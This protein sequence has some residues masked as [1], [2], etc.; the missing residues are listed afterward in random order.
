MKK[1]TQ[2]WRQQKSGSFPRN[3]AKEEAH[4]PP[5]GSATMTKRLGRLPVT[6]T[7]RKVVAMVTNTG[8]GDHLQ[9]GCGSSMVNTTNNT[10]FTLDLDEDL[11]SAVELMEQDLKSGKSPRRHLP[12]SKSPL[13][14]STP[15]TS[16]KR[17]NGNWS[18]KK[19]TSGNVSAGL[20]GSRDRPVQVGITL[21]GKRRREARQAGNKSVKKKNL[22]SFSNNNKSLT[23]SNSP[24]DKKKCSGLENNDSVKKV[25]KSVMPLHISVDKSPHKSSSSGIHF[26][27]IKSGGSESVKRFTDLQQKN[28]TKGKE[29]LF[30]DTSQVNERKSE[31]RSKQDAPENS[32]S[33]IPGIFSLMKNNNRIDTNSVDKNLFS[34]KSSYETGEGDHEDKGKTKTLTKVSTEDSK[35]STVPCQMN[36][37]SSEKTSKEGEIDKLST[38]VGVSGES[39]DSSRL[40]LSSWGLPEPVLKQYNSMGITQMFE[41]QAECLCIGNVLGGGN[42]VYAAP[43]SAGKTM[44]AELLILKRV[45]ETRKKALFILPFVSVTREKMFSLQQLYQDA[46]IRVSGFMGGY[47]PPGGFN[48]VDV[49]VCTIEK[50]NSLINRLIEEKTTDQLGIIVVDELHMVGDSHRGYLLELLLTKIAY[51]ANKG[52]PKAGEKSS[53]DYNPVQIVG[54]SATLPNLDLLARWLHADVFRTDFRPVPLTECLKLGAVLFNSE[55]RKIGDINMCH[56]CKGDEDHIIPLCLETVLAGHAVLIFC[57][58]KNWCEKLCETIAREFYM[59]MKNPPTAATDKGQGFQKAS[60]LFR[61]PLNATALRDVYLQL[62]RTPVGVDSTLGKTVPYGVAFH[63]AGLTFDERDI[64][65]GAFRNGSLKVLVATSTLSSG[66]NLPARRVIIRSVMFHGKVIEA[67]TYKQMAGRAGRK[68]VD[69]AGEC[70]LVC[71]QNEKTKAINLMKSELP[72]VK[73]CLIRED[74]EG[75]SSCM[76]RAILEIVVSGVAVAPVDVAAYASC[77]MLAASMSTEHSQTGELIEA[78]ITFLQEN[79]FVTLKSETD[80][81]G[82][83]TE[84]FYPTQLGAAV[85]ASA[86]SPDEGL[87]VF[88]EL[89]RAR[90]CFVLE[91]ELHVIYL[92]TPIYSHEIS[93]SIDWYQFYC[94]WEKLSPSAL[95][96]A[97][98]VGVQESFI[99]RA[100]RGRILMKTDGQLRSLGIHRRFYTSLVLLDLV[101]EV[102]LPEV[103]RR[104]SCNKGQLQSLQ[105]SAATFAGMVTVFCGRLGWYN[106]ELI[107]SQFQNRLTFG[108]Q[109]ELCDLVRVS[110][111]NGQR[112]RTLYNGGYQTIASLANADSSDVENLLK[113]SAP[114]QSTK[115][116]DGESEWELAERRK[117]HCIWL[118][119]K[120]GVTELEAAQAIISEA[121]SIIE[122]ELGGLGIQWRSSETQKEQTSPVSAEQDGITDKRN[123]SGNISRTRRSSRSSKK[124]PSNKTVS[125]LNITNTCN[126]DRSFVGEVLSPPPAMRKCSQPTAQSPLAANRVEINI[127]NSKNPVV[128][129]QMECMLQL[130]KPSIKTCNLQVPDSE[131]KKSSTE[132]CLFNDVSPTVSFNKM[133]AKKH[134]RTVKKD[135]PQTSENK[136]RNDFSADARRLDNSVLKDFQIT[137]CDSVHQVTKS[138]D[139][140]QIKKCDGVHNTVERVE[141]NETENV[142]GDVKVDGHSNAMF[143]P[144]DDDD[145]PRI[146]LEPVVNI[147][148]TSDLMNDNLT[149][150]MFSQSFSAET[151]LSL[152]QKAQVVKPH[153][154]S[155]KDDGGESDQMQDDEFTDSFLFNTQIS[156]EIADVVK[157]NPMCPVRV[158][159]KNGDDQC[160]TEKKETSPNLFT[161]QSENLLQG[162]D[163]VRLDMDRKAEVKLS[164]NKKCVFK[165]MLAEDC[166]CSLQKDDDCSVLV[167]ASNY[168][169]VNY[170]SSDFMDSTFQDDAN[171]SYTELRIPNADVKNKPESFNRA[172]DR[173]V[174][175]TVVIN[176][177]TE[178]KTAVACIYPGTGFNENISM[179]D[180]FSCSLADAAMENVNALTID[181]ANN[182][183][184]TYTPIAAVGTDDSWT[185]SMMEKVLD[186]QFE[187]S[188]PEEETRKLS[189]NDRKLGD[190]DNNDFLSVITKHTEAT[191]E[192]TKVDQQNMESGST[193]MCSNSIQSSHFNKKSDSQ[194]LCFNKKAME[195][196][197]SNKPKQKSSD[198]DVDKRIEENKDSPDD[199]DS[200]QNISTGSDCLPPT[201]P[202]NNNVVMSPRLRYTPARKARGRLQQNQVDKSTE[203]HKNL[204]SH[205]TKLKKKTSPKDKSNSKQ[206]SN[207][208][209]NK[210]GHVNESS[211]GHKKPG[212]TQT[213]D[214]R[215]G[216]WMMNGVLQK[217]YQGCGDNEDLASCLDR[218]TNPVSVSDNKKADVHSLSFN[219]D[220]AS[221]LDGERTS[222]SVGASG[223]EDKLPDPLVQKD[224]VGDC[225]ESAD[226][227]FLLTQQSFTIIDVCA[228]KMLFQRF[229]SE[230][231][232]KSRYSLCLACE[233]KP[234]PPPQPGVG[235]GGNFIKNTTS[236]A[237]PDSTE[238]DLGDGRIVV[239]MAVSWENRDTYYISL[240]NTQV[241]GD[242]NDS[243]APPPLDSTL[244]VAQRLEAIKTVIESS[245][246]K[247][248]ITIDVYDVKCQYS[249]MCRGCGVQ[250]SGRFHDPRV[251]HWLLDPGARE[252]N[253]HGLVTNFIPSE[254][255]LLQGVGGS[256]GRGS[257]GLAAQKTGTGR[258][259][260]TVESVLAWKLMDYFLEKLKEK[261]LFSAFSSVEMPAVIIMARM[262]LNGFGF[263]ETECES[264]KN[265][266]LAKMS[267]LEE[268]AYQ[269][270]GHPFSLSSTEDVSQV[271]YTE[272]QL[273]INGDPK[274]VPPL[275]RTLGPNRRG[276]GSNRGKQKTS[277]STSK[278]VLEKLKLFH[279]LPGVILEWRRITNALTK[280]VFP[281]QKEKMFCPKLDMYRIFSECQFHTA[282]GRVSMSEPNLQNVPKDFQITL[283]DVIGDSPTGNGMAASHRNTR[284]SS[285]L[286]QEFAAGR[287]VSRVTEN[288]TAPSVAVSMRHAFIPFKGGVIVAAD[289]SQLE[290]R[291]IAHLSQDRKL[292]SI[293]NNDGDV[294]KM[295]AAQWKRTTVEEITAEY[296]QQA[297]QICYGMLYGIGPKALGEQIE[298]DENEAAVFME[299]F[300]SRYPGL[301]TYLRTVVDFCREKGYVETIMGRRR[302]LST[303]KD[304]NPHAR[305]QAERQAVNTTVQGSAAD[306]VKTAMVR[307][308]D[309]LRTRFPDCHFT[310]RHRTEPVYDNLQS[311]KSSVDVSMTPKG[312]F[313]VLQLHDELIYEVSTR[314][315]TAAAQLIKHHMEHAMKLS[316][317]L[318]V[319]VKVGPSWGRLEDLG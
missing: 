111:L 7:T 25:N 68:G 127:L 285:R 73:S 181:K 232:E 110:L 172:L 57:P 273:P 50:G 71:K 241:E 66:V 245:P 122:A 174:A 303:I 106:L 120:K 114:F 119:G 315:L 54:M 200:L 185:F 104:Y 11:I 126:K 188:S 312:A 212:V 251:A 169:R 215:N 305:A 294:F 79:E 55:M 40:L 216:S 196:T 145:I 262:D 64:I 170:T 65:E 316:V 234:A 102:P 118:T 176:N 108:I 90:R 134:D 195:Q 221:C 75:L 6:V 230:W 271:L 152:S 163:D 240:T 296:R 38:I 82:V 277:L 223:D 298:V 194:S 179:S 293:L 116:S 112:A 142:K 52:R 63:H 148:T 29:Y 47:S 34:K 22:L 86:L 16:C 84:R 62:Q 74:H 242:P 248:P 264:Q 51:V 139:I 157:D 115:R 177:E 28:D 266:M 219:K 168:D 43:T 105:Q 87:S 228:D 235:I 309:G 227:S 94:M 91:S 239:G 103:V 220:L 226:Y 189:K 44:V 283:P 154:D 37:T 41:W 135:F 197:V 190:G 319:K 30:N 88:A 300:K 225:D 307:I 33:T 12:L 164:F 308:D 258:Y 175:D 89:Q 80:E 49:A 288:S 81:A 243:L 129:K 130:N 282:T 209:V 222:V 250:P 31:D 70:I 35:I 56:V 272:L 100:V 275:L 186:D 311:Q 61:I 259:R 9:N 314:E 292:I 20:S 202:D 144:V 287:Q 18:N 78:C 39:S 310:H 36:K 265:V 46:G 121:K 302:Y 67:L 131:Q 42:L 5:A 77:T 233:K 201:P 183:C 83:K 301:R 24:A 261:S 205:H 299:T 278:D 153:Q 59:M 167:A 1:L 295:I 291:I 123:S 2:T 132:K 276:V 284:K 289:Y 306:L 263:S 72:P 279:P 204:N 138:N 125:A 318:P 218:Q 236:V 290:L 10:S 286:R 210:N 151:L 214:S 280:H 257:L 269:T 158:S 208:K 98:L 182:D 147:V 150:D 198:I 193:G 143:L 207:S 238:L 26:T 85:L 149:E 246:T 165:T 96:V 156:N 124:S 161:E 15:I 93:S 260:A 224:G 4:G 211:K 58:T 297:K 199:A 76:K 141:K 217:P 191:F 255:P 192:P 137:K 173:Q 162:D 117:A 237:M 27:T 19:Q 128:Q 23:P 267:A 48:A 159:F 253:L 247:D 184:K 97:E 281:L 203:L 256:T 270:A 69:T 274:A 206:C 252:L 249:V 244:T 229:I 133:F 95:R 171:A 113:T 160:N 187:V 92:V 231:R 178:C 213:L 13:V 140:Q 107:L 146:P 313:P 155:A 109:R 8:K 14:C 304:T 21:S 166:I 17:S 136:T 32:A 317:H 3:T 45:L 101:S 254:I 99:A 60:E 53:G 268:Q 180:S